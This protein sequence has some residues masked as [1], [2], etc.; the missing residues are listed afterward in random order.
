MS[1]HPEQSYL[2][3]AFEDTRFA[4]TR[5]RRVRRRLVVAEAALLTALVA[6]VLV[7]VATGPGETTRD[8]VSFAVVALGLIAFVPL[9][10]SLN[11]GI[12]GLFDRSGRTLDEHQ[13]RL[14]ERS[15]GAVSMPSLVLHLAA[16][17]GAALLAG[18]A[19]RVDLGLMLG[20]LLWFMAWLM[21]YWHLGWTLPDEDP[22]VDVDA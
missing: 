5:T 6:A 17:S 16:W 21:S 8:A 15:A 12:R 20:F 22:S 19:D 2:A 1:T 4:W 3:R 18:P 13:R 11:L 7:A 14:R 9:H 10:S